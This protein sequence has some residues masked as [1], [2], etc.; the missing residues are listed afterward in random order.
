MCHLAKTGYRQDDA[1]FPIF[2]SPFLPWQYHHNCIGSTSYPGHI[3]VTVVSER[4]GRVCRVVVHNCLIHPHCRNDPPRK[5][6]PWR[7]TKV[8]L[9]V[10]RCLSGSPAGSMTDTLVELARN[11][12]DCAINNPGL[13]FVQLAKSISQSKKVSF[14]VAQ[15]ETLFTVR[16]KKLRYRCLPQIEYCRYNYLILKQLI[17]K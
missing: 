16:F 2:A 5:K 6:S 12:P 14:S 1:K 17:T 9:L 15:T 13:S 8:D 10:G 11:S 3:R 7:E 4:R